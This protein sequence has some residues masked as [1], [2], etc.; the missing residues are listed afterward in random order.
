MKQR[1]T[2]LMLSAA[3]L[4]PTVSVFAADREGK[5]YFSESYNGYVTN[6]MPDK[7]EYAAEET[8]VCEDGKNN[9]ALALTSSRKN[10]TASFPIN[11][12]ED[13]LSVSFDVKFSG[14][15]PDGTLSIK[16]GNTESK[17]L[18]F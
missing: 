6:K 5:I 4:A 10:I 16:N 17:V 14:A 2:A 8:A 11:C 12:E 7:G 18:V 13:K 9:K 3:L 1:I 15:L